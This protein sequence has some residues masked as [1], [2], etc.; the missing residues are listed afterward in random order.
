[1]ATKETNL[2]ETADL[3]RADGERPNPAA[4]RC[5]GGGDSH[6][7]TSSTT[8]CILM[9]VHKEGMADGTH[10]QARRTRA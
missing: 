1:M 4:T 8:W 3:T 9:N 7:Y 5:D 6:Q 10:G 2:D